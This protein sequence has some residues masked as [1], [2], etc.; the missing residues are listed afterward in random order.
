MAD[1][2]L[3]RGD[4]L[5]LVVVLAAFGVVDSAYLT[6]EWYAAESASWCDIGSYF[7]CTRVRESPFSAVG[8]VPTAMVGVLGFGVLAALAGLA[9][10]GTPIWGPWTVDRWLLAFA[11]LGAAIGV[12]LTLIEVFVIEAICLLCVVGFVLDLAILGLVVRLPAG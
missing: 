11:A 9:L 8:G 12:G 4:A 7:S 6:Y 3:S 5:L 1:S 10:R 2:F